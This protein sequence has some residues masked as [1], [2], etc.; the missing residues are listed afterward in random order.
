MLLGGIAEDFQCL[1][2]LP[3]L[4]ALRT[5]TGSTQVQLMSKTFRLSNADLA[6]NTRRMDLLRYWVDG[7]QGLAALLRAHKRIPPVGTLLC[8]KDEID[9]WVR[10]Q[11]PGT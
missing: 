9:G 3:W 4:G 11:L 5:A 2:P 6:N 1:F 7:A 10:S 8:L